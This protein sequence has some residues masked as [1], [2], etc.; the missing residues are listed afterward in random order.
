MVKTVDEGRVE[1]LVR[2]LGD[3]LG[4]VAGHFPGLFHEDGDHV[5]VHF[6]HGEGDDGDGGAHRL[7]EDGDVRRGKVVL[8][9]AEDG[10]TAGHGMDQRGEGAD[11]PFHRVQVVLQSHQGVGE[12]VQS[13]LPWW[14]VSLQQVVD[15]VAAQGIHLASDAL[16]AEEDEGAA[17]FGQV[18][19]D[20]P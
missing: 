15:D 10:E 16:M 2:H 11:A 3:R 13:H 9:V 5:F 19:G 1:V 4:E 6:V 7:V 12:Q 20:L 18:R 14:F 8:G 17:Q